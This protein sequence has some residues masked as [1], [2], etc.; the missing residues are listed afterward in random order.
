MPIRR[1]IV[2]VDDEFLKMDVIDHEGDPWLVPEWLAANDGSHRIPVRMIS[3][4]TVPHQ[5]VPSGEPANLVVND[6]LPKSLLSGPIPEHEARRFRV[7][8][9]PDIRVPTPG[10]GFSRH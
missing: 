5:V 6:P 10:W 9:Y 1:A 4:A 2:V 3:L 7:L 8:D